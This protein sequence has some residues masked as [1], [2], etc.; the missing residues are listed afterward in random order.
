MTLLQLFSGYAPNKVFVAIVSG[1]LSGIFYALLIPVL[2][3]SFNSDLGGLSLIGEQVYTFMGIDFAHPHYALLFFALCLCILITRSIAQIL[4]SRISMDVMTS[5]RQNL[6]HRIA[7]TPISALEQSSSGELIQTMTTDVQ[8]IV[9]GAGIIPDLLIQLATLSG[10][11][12]FLFYLNNH[13]FGFVCVMILFGVVSFQIPMHFGLRY[14]MGARDAMGSLQDSFHGLVDGAKELKLNKPRR[15]HFMEHELLASERAIIDLEKKGFTISR[16]SQNYGDLVSFLTIGTVGFV[17]VNYHPISAVELTGI[18]MTLLYMT[19]PVISIL[20]SIP[21]LARA[22]MSLD[23]LNSLF[24]ELP[25]EDVDEDI[26]PVPHWDAIHINNVSYRYP[27]KPGDAS[28]FGVGPIE[29]TIN[30]G[31]ITFIVGG[32]GSGKSTF[33]KIVSL[34][35]LPVTG[36]MAFGDTILSPKNL[37][38]YRQEIACIYS[39]Y[40]LFKR[41]HG[42]FSDSLLLQE[43][44]NYYL[45]VLDLKEKVS[46]DN[47]CFS[48]LKL[49]DGQRRRLALLVAFL[50]DKNLFVFD[51]WAADQDPHFKQIFYCE[52]LPSLRDQG[53]AVIAISHDDRYFHVADQVIYMEDGQV[54]NNAPSGHK[55]DKKN[56]ATV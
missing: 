7:R 20:N 42:N 1:T 19:G 23:K 27:S 32:N 18:I 53:K 25:K 41:I 12:F 45:D 9:T 13:V 6:Y 11:L 29:L 31:E 2:M 48:T 43:K 3:M 28:A 38:S 44:V 51:E 56:Y 49:S 22:K 10:L 40:Y 24:D 37:N 52:I 33:S 34:H 16:I 55:M 50:D 30:R 5:L 15:E 4:L 54:A 8:R 21:E 46:F 17:Y 36:T 35:Y 26:H 47:G 39:D 14:F